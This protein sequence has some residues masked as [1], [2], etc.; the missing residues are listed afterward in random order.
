MKRWS[1]KTPSWW[2]RIQIGTKLY[3]VENG[4][5]YLCHVVSAF[6][7]ND[8]Q[9]FTIAWYGKHKQW[10]HYEVIDRSHAVYQKVWPYRSPHPDP[11]VQ[12]LIKRVR[13]RL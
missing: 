2:M 3:R 7:H 12:A 1:D 9:H 11:K 4:V 5:R 13:G 10:W 8:R 6:V